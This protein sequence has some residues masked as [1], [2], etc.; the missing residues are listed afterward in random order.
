MAVFFG[1]SVAMMVAMMEFYYAN[2]FGIF[3]A[4]GVMLYIGTMDDLMGLSPN[5]RF[6]V[7]ILVVTML[8]YVNRCQIDDF[9]GLFG[10]HSIS[11]W[12]A[13]PLTV[14]AAVGIINSINLIDGV[15]GLSS[16]YCVMACLIFGVFFYQVGEVS[17]VILAAISAGALIPFFLHNVF[18]ISSKMFIGD[19]GTLVMGIVM[20]TFVVYALCGQSLAS[21]HFPENVGLIP[22]TLAALSVPV[23]D[24]LRV[25]LSRIM[26]GTSPF[27]PD[28]THLHHIFI[29]LGCSHSVTTFTILSL[30][31]LIVLCWVV[32][33]SLGWSIDCQLYVVVILSLLA[34]FGLYQFL[35]WQ[36]KKTTKMY[37]VMNRWGEK[38]HFERRSFYLW[39]QKV[40]DKL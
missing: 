40:I 6:L 31:F 7:E 21:D 11:M 32:M 13:V 12:F 5:L 17:M 4:M 39:L 25:M 28:K 38:T 14:F 2:L 15:N 19:G 23:F 35:D 8:I 30:N 36:I 1:I 29:E 10:V 34:T 18:G 9:H 33:V 37:Y 20:S 3:L 26:R 16:G 27:H 24:T 22:F